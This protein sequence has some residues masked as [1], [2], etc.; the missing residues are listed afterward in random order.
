MIT[1]TIDNQTVQAP[2][3]TTIL[4]AARSLG[5]DIPTLC[6]ADGFKPSTSCMVCVVRV[7]GYKH[8][9]AAC[10]TPVAEGMVVT[11]Q[12][13]EIQTARKTAIELLLSD[14]VGDCVGP[15]EK[16]C[17]AGMN[18][19]LMLRQI[20]AGDLAA[21]IKTVKQDIA[22]PAILGRICTAPCEKVCR[23][24]QADGAVMICLLKRFVADV[25]LAS[26]NPFQPIC[27]PLT[28]KKVA[29]VG[30]GPCGLAA[31]YHLAQAGIECTLLDDHD[32]PG[33]T[34]LAE[35]ID[36]NVVETEIAQILKLGVEFKGNTTLGKDIALD[37]LKKQY[38]AVLLAV[39]NLNDNPPI[40]IEIK[41]NKIQ[42][43]RPD[44]ATS[45]LTVFAAGTCIGSRN[46]CI[47]AVADGKEA[48]TAIAATLTGQ[49][50]SQA[51]YNHRMGRV[52]DEEMA[53]FLKHTAAD[54]RS[55][56]ESATKGLTK[57][58]AQQQSLR[59][60]HCD[61]RKRDACKLRDLA[62][63]LA[64]RQKTFDADRSLFEQ[65]TGRENLIFE[66]G[67]CIKCG[68]CIQTARQK[69][70]RLGVS[71]AG[72]GFG[73]RVTVPLNKTLDEA[74]EIAAVECAAI[75]P[76]GALSL[77]ESN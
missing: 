16:G 29:V 41:D 45:Q 30:A 66:P 52:S 34:L 19:P 17:P 65:I 13:E 74:L 12:S 33:G 48:A 39:G 69:G 55:N 14:H 10:G 42:V 24:A 57:S 50:L 36:P 8:F 38:D 43:S 40:G 35:P 1:L 2:E 68:L 3:G 31:A 11:T 27:Q 23:R 26:D 46:L 37:E 51:A 62:A 58:Q 67:K 32:K 59:C 47:R 49:P 70:E 54:E 15:C 63:D 56:G 6:F 44:F 7:A 64:A 4:Q 22:L 76:T 20:A 73:M 77:A 9:A 18:I 61:C 53:V 72:R 28:G 5:I 25:D 75:C 21:A 71:F 60:L